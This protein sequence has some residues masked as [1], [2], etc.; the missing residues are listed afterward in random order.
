MTQLDLADAL[1]QMQSYVSKSE[2]GDRRLDVIELR[3]W[4]LALGCDPVQF[5]ATLEDRFSRNAS[6][7]SI[8][9]TPLKRAGRKAGQ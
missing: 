8:G 4:L 7:R 6:M 5:A 2:L 3:K 1:G 9:Q